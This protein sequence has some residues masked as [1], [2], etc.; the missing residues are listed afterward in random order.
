MARVSDCC[1]GPPPPAEF[2]SEPSKQLVSGDDGDTCCDGD[3]CC[4]RASANGHADHLVPPQTSCC[5]DKSPK[6]TCC[7]PESTTASAVASCHDGHAAESTAGK[8]PV[9]QKESCQDRCYAGPSQPQAAI[10]NVDQV[11]PIV[12]CCST[13]TEPNRGG[14]R[15]SYCDARTRSCSGCDTSCLDRVALR[16]CEQEKGAVN[17]DDSSTG[18]YNSVLFVAVE[19]DKC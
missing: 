16:A 9:Q 6:D 18:K 10:D 8:Q 15:D 12:R 19:L 5:D 13:P 7:K 14:D 1:D 3:S 2:N 17:F 11:K 4:E